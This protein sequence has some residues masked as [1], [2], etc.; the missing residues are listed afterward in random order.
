MPFLSIIIPVYNK[1]KYLDKC[2]QSIVKQ[3]F[4]DFEII[5]VNDG[6]SDES[7]SICNQW[8]KEDSRIRVI[9][10]QNSGVS[11]ARNNGLKY[12]TGEYIQF[13]DADDWWSEESFRDL[14]KDISIYDSP[15]ILIY[16]MTKVYPNGNSKKIHPHALGRIALKDFLSNLIVEQKETGVYG[17]VCNKLTARHIINTHHIQFNPSYNLIEDYDFYIT[18]FEHSQSIALS[19]QCGYH[20]L[21][22]AENSTFSPSFRFHYPH[23]MA[24][25]M[26][27]YNL[28][29]KVCGYI[30]ANHDILQEE[31]ENLYLGMYVELGTPNYN[32]I[33]KL[34]T[35]VK[36]LLDGKFTLTPQGT[37]IN[38]KI[39]S[40]LL[41]KQLFL[42]LSIYLKLRKLISH[43]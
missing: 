20:Y 15:D 27:A 14:F 3:S 35:E 9:H 8:Q 13:S 30:K 38:T 11:N 40:F 34:R 36:A 42:F 19:H 17:A 29:D 1:G 18:C 41:K 37:S 31:L 5:L 22:E 2:I 32:T 25:R 33:D 26:K 4:T 10:Q 43:A 39:I 7:G 21:Q 6:S 24:I 23:V 12:A 16:G 28:T